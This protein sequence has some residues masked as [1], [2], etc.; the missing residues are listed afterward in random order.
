MPYY[1]VQQQLDGPSVSM[2]PLGVQQQQAEGGKR[3]RQQEWREKDEE[4]AKRRR[5]WGGLQAALLT[6]TQALEEARALLVAE[7]SSVVGGARTE[8]AAVTEA[9]ATLKQKVKPELEQGSLPEAWHDV[10][11]LS[12]EKDKLAERVERLE[13]V[14]VAAASLNVGPKVEEAA[15]AVAQDLEFLVGAGSA[16]T[17]AAQGY[18]QALRVCV[19]ARAAAVEAAMAVL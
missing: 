17:A 19:T 4:V 10:L 9:C 8:L 7:V 3:Q 16:A 2:P 18:I 5:H 1:G 14:E 15:R 12:D 6:A 13:A 11:L